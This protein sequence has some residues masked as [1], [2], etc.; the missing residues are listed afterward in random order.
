MSN[1]YN[2]RPPSK[3]EVLKKHISGS[4][5]YNGPDMFISYM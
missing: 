2:M 4:L 3:E 5:V 1:S